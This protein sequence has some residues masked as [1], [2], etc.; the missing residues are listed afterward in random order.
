MKYCSKCGA[1]LFDEAVI[2]VKC[3]CPVSPQYAYAREPQKKAPKTSGFR[4]ASMVLLI[5]TLSIVALYAGL[6]SFVALIGAFGGAEF[7]VMLIVALIFLAPLAW[8]IPMLVVY[9]KAVKRKSPIGV[10]LKV[11]ILIFF[12]V[13]AGIL[14]LCDSEEEQDESVA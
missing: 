14:L 7:F 11:C 10:G 9:C 13:V 5:V 12:N 4:I 2:C 3:G 1:E 6:F 8:M